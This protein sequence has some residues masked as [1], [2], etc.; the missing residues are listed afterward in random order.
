MLLGAAVQDSV[1][2]PG[3]DSGFVGSESSRLTPATAASP[4]HQRATE[5]RGPHTFHSSTPGSHRQRLPL[6]PPGGGAGAR[7]VR[8]KEF[9]FTVV[10]LNARQ[11]SWVI[12][13]SWGPG[14]N[15]SSCCATGLNAG[16][17]DAVHCRRTA[18]AVSVKQGSIF[19]AASSCFPPHWCRSPVS[20]SQPPGGSGPQPQA[21]GPPVVVGRAVPVRPSR[22]CGGRRAPAASGPR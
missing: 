2:S 4:L 18:D 1:V 11:A 21:G 3:T 10:S 22:G 9:G 19:T 5:R 17:Y 20:V 13:P 15:Q 16:R 14:V 8:A 12:A 7:F 6:W